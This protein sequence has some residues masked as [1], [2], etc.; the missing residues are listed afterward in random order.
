M[1]YGWTRQ[2]IILSKK[3]SIPAS[4]LADYPM[5]VTLIYIPD[6]FLIFF[7]A[8]ES[9]KTKIV[10]LLDPVLLFMILLNIQMLFM[11]LLI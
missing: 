7:P 6:H 9:Q 5:V 3:D 8:Y 2:S 4:V 11:C 10:L 1:Y